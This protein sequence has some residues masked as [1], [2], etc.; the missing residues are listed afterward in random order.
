MCRRAES[1]YTHVTLHALSAAIPQAFLLLHAIL[2]VLPFPKS[3][4]RYEIYTGS[5]ECVDEVEDGVAADFAMEASVPK[6]AVR[7]KSSLRVEVY[8]GDEAL[9]HKAKKAGG[10]KKP[11]LNKKRR[12]ARA[13][14]VEGGERGEDVGVVI[15]RNVQD[16]EMAM[17]A[18]ELEEETEMLENR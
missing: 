6:R 4:M 16:E 3:A 8:V 18:D 2:D 12:A 17:N 9:K 11:R 1:R 15:S 13:G 14:A 10:A 5:V 7:V